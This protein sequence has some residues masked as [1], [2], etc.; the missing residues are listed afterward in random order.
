MHLPQI[1]SLRWKLD[2]SLA[3]GLSPDLRKSAV[4]IAPHPDDEVLGCGG[5]IAR[6]IEERAMVHLVFMT[7]GAT[8]HR[9]FIPSGEL[10]RIRR[11]EAIEA[12]R[13]LGVSEGHIT[14]LDYP[15]GRLHT[16]REAA[17]SRVTAFLATL[18]PEE[19]FV[20]Y[21]F[22]GTSDHEET[23]AIVIE[24]IRG[25]HIPTRVFEYPVWFW[26]QWPWVSLPLRPN[27]QMLNALRRS[28]RFGLG[29]TARQTFTHGVD[30]RR[31]VDK[32]RQ[33]LAA[34]RSQVT[35]LNGDPAWPILGDVSDGQFIACMTGDYEVFAANDG[36]F[37]SKPLNF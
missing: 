26:N 25:A 6:K 2:R 34:H 22:D 28:L 17:V 16:A 30:V 35:R 7:D 14:F 8:S 20:P 15:D 12:A 29:R 27:R 36:E 10:V 37:C 24:A 31:V 23:Y 1:T 4:I 3:C 11:G 19:V 33:A 32:K 5:T 13:I 9:R 18:H 21:R